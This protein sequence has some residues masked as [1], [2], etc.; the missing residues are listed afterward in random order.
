MRTLVISFLLLTNIFATGTKQNSDLSPISNS[1]KWYKGNTHT[2]AKFSDDNDINDVPAI[3]KW[4]ESA[5][6]NFI[7]LSEHN[8]RVVKKQVI[9][10]E[11]ASDKPN[12]IMLCGLELS[13]KRHH[14]ALG[15]DKYIGDESSLQDGVNKT[16]SAGGVPILNHPQDPVVSS[17]NFLATSGLNHFEVFNGQRPEQT[18]ATEV[19]WDS[20]LSSQNGRPV[21]AV[22]SD[23]NHYKESSVGRGW[24]MVKSPSLTPEDIEENIR[25]GNFYASTGVFITDYQ[26]SKKTIKINT[27]NGNSISFIGKNG[28]VLSTVKGSGATYSIKG[29]ELYIRS[30]IT[31]DKGKSAWTQPVFVN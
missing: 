16:L 4:Y 31:N 2:H 30:K 13:K 3:A 17:K 26:V 1:N 24:I 25:K 27:E 21:F 28:V 7:L 22:A 6:Y 18:P 10:H 8:N 23:D 20:I 11:E 12:F 19:L 29:N 5:G 15:I 9:C 14:T